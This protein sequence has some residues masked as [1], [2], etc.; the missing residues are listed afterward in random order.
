MAGITGIGS[1]IDINSI[2]TALVNAERA[3]K[4]SQL[5]R[6][7]TQTTSKLSALGTLRSAV[8][9]LNS[10]VQSLNTLSAF[11]QQL[12]SS[13]SSA[14]VTA[15]A[16]KE[17]PAASFSLQIQ[18]LAS[19]SKI[20]LRAVSGG[21]SATFNSGTLTL[22]AG[23]TS[24]GIAVSAGSNSLS[25]IRDAINTQG[26]GLGFS[27]SIVSDASGSRLL[28]S[29]SKSGDGNGLVVS[30]TED[31]LTSGS[32]ALLDQA[33]SPTEG[34][35][36]A[37]LT[38]GP[39]SRFNAGVLSIST[40]A[41]TFNVSINA[42]ATLT[43]LR[44]AITSAG[45]ASGVAASIETSAAGT[46]LVMNSSSGNSLT[47]SSAVSSSSLL[48]PQVA[49]PTEAFRAGSL[50]IGAGSS[51]FNLVVSDG[52]TLEALRDRINNE[53]IGFS[54]SVETSGTGSALRVTSA[55]GES[56][57]VVGS[58]SGGASANGL[59]TLTAALPAT[60]SLLSSLSG[61]YTSIGSSAPNAITGAAGVVSRAQSARFSIDG[62]QQVKE[63]NSFS[64]VVDGLTINLLS[65]Q[66]AA[67]IAAGRSI[68]ISVSEDKSTAR[69]NLQKFVDSYNKLMQSTS[70]LTAYVSVG[71][72]KP[73]VTGALLGDSGVRNLLSGLRKELVKPVSP[74]EITSLA[75][76]GVTTGKDGK[77]SIDPGKLDAALS[78][79]YDQVAGFLGGPGGLME[80]LSTA[81]KPFAEAN[82]LIEQRQKSLQ[83]TLS[84][85]DK[86]RAALEL[87]IA[88]V[89]ERLF[90]Q[91]NA[92]DALVGQLQKTS[93]SL[94]SQLASLPGFVKP[95]K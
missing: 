27:A 19:G 25:A 39:G 91:Y 6:L 94:A 81:L 38:G 8:S 35:A 12:V 77:L 3:P 29:S 23:S 11:Q 28:I 52:E 57:S 54:A 7:E 51:S 20:G 21:Q 50:L 78:R 49:G 92:M 63:R 53:S 66:S 74:L 18:Q 13:S 80:R 55:N 14:N 85:I 48:L 60:D 75:Q 10:S 34:F 37:L 2:V 30:A 46:R 15:T 71:E 84:G 64:D 76:I 24:L 40:G 42:G 82:G 93:E 41:S 70:E 26:A 67:D 58:D 95:Q 62:L 83:V 1:G 45:A 73:P 59:D 88:K 61:S 43:E 17:L 89:Q 86:Q 4:E 47:V 87:R 32:N 44:D 56:I 31:G 69:S 36:S 9:G 16:S 33:F 72:G 79:N 22:T 5:K 68:T 90:S 65:A